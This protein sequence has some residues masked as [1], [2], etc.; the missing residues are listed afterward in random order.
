[1]VPP[2][3]NFLPDIDAFRDAVTPKTRG[4][5]I[6]SP[7]NPTGVLYSS[8]VLS[9]LCEIIREKE[10]EYGTKIY[11]VSDEPYRRLIFDNLKYPHIFDHHVRSIVATS[12]SKD[13]VSYTHLEPTR[14]RDIADAGVGGKKKGGGGG[15]G[16]FVTGR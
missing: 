8:E 7:N 12:H 11:L 9:N 13:P 5:L 14:P 10:E 2:D 1:M 6:N 4:V 3:R 15:G 16:V